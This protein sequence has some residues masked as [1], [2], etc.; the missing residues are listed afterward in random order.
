MLNVRLS[1]PIDMKT[2]KEKLR[3]SKFAINKSRKDSTYLKVK[4]KIKYNAAEIKNQTNKLKSNY[5]EYY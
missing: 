3:L 5:D 1:E 2:N 4:K